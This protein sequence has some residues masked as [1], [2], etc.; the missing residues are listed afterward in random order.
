[1]KLEFEKVDNVPV[2]TSGKDYENTLKDFNASGNKCVQILSKTGSTT[3]G[4]LKRAIRR[5]KFSHI[6]ATSSKGVVYLINF[7]V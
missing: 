5:L 7:K 3:V 6:E 1:M 4:G 2:R